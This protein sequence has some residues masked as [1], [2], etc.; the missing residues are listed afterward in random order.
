MPLIGLAGYA[1]ACILVSSSADES[2]RNAERLLATGQADEA[3]HRLRWVVWFQPDHPGANLLI[4]QSHLESQEYDAAILR[5][6]S[7][8]ETAPEFGRA[9]QTLA[10]CLLNQNQLEKAEL[11]LR[12]LIE[13]SPQSLPIHRELAVLLLGQLRSDEAVEVLL[14]FLDGAKD[15]SVADRLVVLR[16]LLKSQFLAP[17]PEDCIDSLQAA[18]SQHP[19]QTTVAVALADCLLRLG[20]ETEAEQIIRQL[21]ARQPSSPAVQILKLQLTVD[22][23]N[24][25]DARRSISDVEQT[26]TSTMSDSPYLAAKFFLLK[27]LLDEN[28]GN[29]QAAMESLERA[30]TIR[31]LDRPS[32][33]R[34]ARMMQR[35]GKTDS[36]SELFATIHHQAEAELALWHMTGKVLD[37]TPSRK[38]CEKISALFETP[39][40]PTQSEAWRRAGE[41]LNLATSNVTSLESRM[42][43]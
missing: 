3:R 14:Q 25:A 32:R 28:D 4:G 31:P 42:P 40:K 39:E 29:F 5:F 22:L 18:D 13:S 34:H 38:E 9:Q 26:V 19:G 11:I 2:I 16:D 36:A 33:I 43:K 12:Q 6:E 15:L 23:R 10:G 1:F 8:K 30:A 17:L 27:S 24:Y 41:E 21:Q 35:T 7:V 37:R 20:R